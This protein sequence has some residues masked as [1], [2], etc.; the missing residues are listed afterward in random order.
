MTPSSSKHTKRQTLTILLNGVITTAFYPLSSYAKTPL[1]DT[2]S[3]L[4]MSMR[5]ANIS[6][7]E[8]FAKNDVRLV[9]WAVIADALFINR[10]QDERVLAK[11]SST[12][13]AG[14]F[15][16]TLK[17]LSERAVGRIKREGLRLALNPADIETALAVEARVVLST[18][19]PTTWEGDVTLFS[20]HFRRSIKRSKCHDI[21]SK[22]DWW[23]ER[24]TY[25]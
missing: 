15:L 24:L 18:E 22:T 2:H 25:D 6:L 8:Q 14:D 20:S 17:Q 1:S 23:L 7:R 19:G 21:S 10:T 9:S 11:S 13:Q 12:V 4:G 5:K 16:N 3:H